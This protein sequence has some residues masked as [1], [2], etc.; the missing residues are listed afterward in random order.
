MLTYQRENSYVIC[1]Q[2]VAAVFIISSEV[3]SAAANSNE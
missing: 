2:P 1:N 3:F